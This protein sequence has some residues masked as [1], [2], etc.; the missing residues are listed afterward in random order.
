MKK[1]SS[2][3]K[4]LIPPFL[5]CWLPVH[6]LHLHTVS[7]QRSAAVKLVIPARELRGSLLS[8][9]RVVVNYRVCVSKASIR[10]CGPGMVLD[11]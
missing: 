6:M 5:S 7:A 3:R 8:L 4:K 9:S 2:Y 10:A 1:V 11:W